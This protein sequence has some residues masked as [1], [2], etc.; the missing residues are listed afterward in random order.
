MGL[1]RGVGG[2][3]DCL[4]AAG[5]RS[6]WPSR[7]KA[8]PA[9]TTV[10]LGVLVAWSAARAERR[11]LR[12][13]SAR[14]LAVDSNQWAVL[15]RHGRGY[16]SQLP[17]LAVWGT[18]SELPVAVIGETGRRRCDRQR[19]ILEG[20]R[21]A[22]WSGHY[23]AVRYD[24]ASASVA[25]RIKRLAEK[26]HLTGPAFMAAPQ[27]TVEEISALS[28]IC[29]IDERVLE[30]PDADVPDAEADH[31]FDVPEVHAAPSPLASPTTV[32][33]PLPSSEPESPEA[34]AERERRYRETFG[35]PEPK[36]GRLW[37]R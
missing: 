27:T 9:P 28:P 20:W 34:A 26:V 33:A 17:D 31:Q 24:C 15:I 1:G 13:A 30:P 6:W 4:R 37:R 18:R 21:D 19:W 12:W 23:S 10:A 5:D 11:G 29:D 3:A 16:R 35:I 32:Q 14:E 7:R 25:A 22:I 2:L 36:R 8:P